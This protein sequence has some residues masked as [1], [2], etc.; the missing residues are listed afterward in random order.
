[1]ITDNFSSKLE[2]HIPLGKESLGRPNPSQA[3]RTQG[4]LQD[5]LK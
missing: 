3:L 4:Q 2:V 5:Q 1:M